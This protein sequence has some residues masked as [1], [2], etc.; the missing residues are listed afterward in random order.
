MAVIDADAALTMRLS[1]ELMDAQ[2]VIRRQR[3][4]IRLLTAALVTERRASSALTEVL[5]LVLEDGD[6]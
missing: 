5:E 6:V 3:R 1:S 4:R 2:A